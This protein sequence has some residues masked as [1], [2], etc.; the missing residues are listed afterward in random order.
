VTGGLE[1]GLL[2]KH[3]ILYAKA[4]LD[5][6]S[7]VAFAATMGVGICLSAVPVV[8]YQGTIAL[9]AGT[10]RPYL[11]SDVI[12]ELSAVGGL[13]IFAIGLNLLEL[14]EIR[15]AN[16]LPAFLVIMA[17]MGLLL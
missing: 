11:G 4:V 1:S 9:A 12:V 14:K 3:S 8:L 5:G 2:A 13:L 10:L 6:V 16:F 7:A 15:V 17:W